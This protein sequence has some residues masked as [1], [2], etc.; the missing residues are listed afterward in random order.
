MIAHASAFTGATYWI[1]SPSHTK[2]YHVHIF[3]DIA[4]LQQFVLQ[5]NI[6]NIG[7]VRGHCNIKVSLYH[8]SILLRIR[9]V[10]ILEVGPW[11]RYTLILKPVYIFLDSPWTWTPDLTRKYRT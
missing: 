10:F 7:Y 3:E 2:Q 9:Y 8:Q 11:W 1:G 6:Q 4:P 5:L